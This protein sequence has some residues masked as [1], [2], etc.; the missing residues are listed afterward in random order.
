LQPEITDC[1]NSD[2]ISCNSPVFPYNNPSDSNYDCN[3]EYC[4]VNIKYLRLRTLQIG[5]NIPQAWAEK[6]Q[7]KKPRIYLN[8]Y[9]LFSF[10]NLKSKA[11]FL[12]PEVND[13]NGLQ[14]PQMKTVSLGVNLTF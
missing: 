4:L 2:L 12:D 9:N 11:S 14:Y 1:S 6:L 5:Y 3:S 13:D 10:D 8:G 7:M